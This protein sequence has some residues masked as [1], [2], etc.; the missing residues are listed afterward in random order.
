MK[1]FLILPYYLYWHYT[2]GFKNLVYNFG[3]L[4]IFEIHFFSIHELFATLFS[5]F[6]RL[7]ESSSKNLSN[8]KELPSS[9]LINSI[10]R[11]VGF[12]CRMIIICAGICVLGAT[13]LILPL[14]MIMWLVLP[15]AILFF[16]TVTMISYITYKP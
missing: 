2:K 6:Q 9:F 16:M 12:F 10:M 8:L 1:F 11:I 3:S 15:F 14:L 13:V 5:P 7:I 4:L